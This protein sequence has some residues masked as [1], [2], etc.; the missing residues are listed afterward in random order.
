MKP[1]L[2]ILSR[3]DYHQVYFNASSILCSP[4]AFSSFFLPPCQFLELASM[5]HVHVCLRVCIHG[6]VYACA[7]GGKRSTSNVV[8]HLI[9]RRGLSLT[10]GLTDLPR[11]AVQQ[12]PESFLLPPPH[13]EDGW[14]AVALLPRCRGP[15][16]DPHPCAV[17]YW[18]ISKDLCPVSI[19]DAIVLLCF[20]LT[21][22]DFPCGLG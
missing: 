21:H 13:L 1:R 2:S 14:H 4:N 20:S 15:N 17:T 5:L 9:L 16:S 12:A 18:A 7:V 10:L 8:L 3:W 22:L 6:H 19:P 11:L